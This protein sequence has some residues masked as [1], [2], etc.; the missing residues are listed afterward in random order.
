MTEKYKVEFGIAGQRYGNPFPVLDR[1]EALQLSNE[2]Q[3]LGIQHEIYKGS[4]G[5]QLGRLI[6]E[7]KISRDYLEK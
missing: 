6:D 3:K 4:A 7:Q 5:I 1:E 2:L